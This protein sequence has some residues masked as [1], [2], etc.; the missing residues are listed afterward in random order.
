MVE[1][2]DEAISE[3]LMQVMEDQ[4]ASIAEEI[5]EESCEVTETGQPADDM[6]VDED[7]RKGFRATLSGYVR[8]I[9]NGVVGGK[10]DDTDEREGTADKK[11][12]LDGDGL[13][14]GCKQRRII[15]R[16]TSLP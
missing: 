4:A 13:E 3:E 7:K 14:A 9:A 1:R 16:H 5:M 2:T 10:N 15:E 6:C 8:G 12:V 11:K